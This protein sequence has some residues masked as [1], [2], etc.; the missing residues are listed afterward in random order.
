MS[1]DQCAC[2][3]QKPGVLLL[4]RRKG[5]AIRRSLHGYDVEIDYAFH[6]L[7][8]I[9]QL[10]NAKQAVEGKIGNIGLDGLFDCIPH[11]GQRDSRYI[12]HGAH[13]PQKVSGLVDNTD[14]RT[15]RF[16]LVNRS[17]TLF[18]RPGQPVPAAH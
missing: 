12:P 4:K 3:L 10:D 9:D 16:P 14:K 1:L 17:R 8:F 13:D 6:L 5:L 11:R 15:R 2:G 18:E 7:H